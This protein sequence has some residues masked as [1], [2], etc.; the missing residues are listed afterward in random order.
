MGGDWKNPNPLRDFAMAR[1]L[2]QTEPLF[3][4]PVIQ[5]RSLWSPFQDFLWFHLIPSQFTRRNSQPGFLCS[6]GQLCLTLLWAS[7]VGSPALASHEPL[8]VSGIL[9]H[10]LFGRRRSPLIL[11][12]DA[13]WVR[14]KGEE[15]LGVTDER[16]LLNRSCSL[17]GILRSAT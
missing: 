16:S 6:L 2:V 1:R 7:L 9:S 14:C 8:L 5:V 4:K 3:S 17:E 15:G 13:I 12:I 11:Q 10:V